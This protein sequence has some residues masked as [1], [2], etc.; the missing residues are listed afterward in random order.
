LFSLAVAVLAGYAADWLMRWHPPR[1]FV[2]SATVLAGVAL[3][4][5]LWMALDHASSALRPPPSAEVTAH[6]E[7]YLRIPGLPAVVDGVP[8]TPATLAQLAG[9]AL[10]PSTPAMALQLLLIGAAGLTI[11]LWLSHPRLRI[12][13][14]CA[15]VALILVDLGVVAST[16]HPYARLTELR[17]IVP[18]ILTR[19]RDRPFRIYTPPIAEAKTIPIEPNRLLVEGIDE[20]GGYSSLAPDRHA[21]YAAAARYTNS[22]LMDLWNV[23]YVVRRQTPALL[24]SHG[25]TSFH[26]GHPLMRGSSVAAT[27]RFLPDGGDV[28]ANELRVIAALWGATTVADGTPVARIILHEPDGTA[29]GLTLE[30]GRDVADTTLDV[31]GT[32]LRTGR[33]RPDVAF[34]YPRD[35]HRSARFGEQLYYARL[36]VSPSMLVSQV[37]IEPLPSQVGIE[38][39][40]LGLVDVETL[41]VTQV[42]DAAKY[43]EVYSDEQISILRN[44]DALPRAFLTTSALTVPP[45][46]DALSLLLDGE[47]DVSRTAVLEEPLPSGLELRQ[48]E[49]V[50]SAG[51]PGRASIESY[52]P[53]KIIVRT[54]VEQRALLMLTDI[55]FPGWTARVDG[56]P[57]PIVRANYLF[58]AVPV[59]AGTHSVVFSYEPMSVTFGAGI[60]AVTASIV[61]IFAILLLLAKRRAPAIVSTQ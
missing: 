43:R 26:P 44:V 16:S 45:G 51:A 31:P 46:R 40:G 13:G 53:T 52:E 33:A 48:P 30:A 15:A 18:E 59:P 10:S 55:Y 21:A 7:A 2:A 38:V 14:A 27:R 17:P 37:T 57:V 47:I 28:R 6:L 54:E 39:Y 41:E 36:P 1:P 19:D 23:R 11:G 56:R 35:D 49:I 24:P 32:E 34:Q 4:S 29:R 9:D 60:S 12:P 22:R 42:R 8:L 20:A 25:G 3:V 50:T 58:R 61:L 5:G